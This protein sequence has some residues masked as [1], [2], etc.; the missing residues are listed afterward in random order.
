MSILFS[1]F[2]WVLGAIANAGSTDPLA[3]MVVVS[4][5]HFGIATI[6]LF[7]LAR[8]F[9]FLDEPIGGTR[10]IFLFGLL[11]AGLLGLAMIALLIMLRG[12]PNAPDGVLE[13]A[14]QQVRA[15]GVPAIAAWTGYVLGLVLQAAFSSRRQAKH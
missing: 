9:L 3:L 1:V 12:S 14:Q 15:H 4:S 8:L 10:D 13:L 6:A 11:S 5:L 2:G 7:L